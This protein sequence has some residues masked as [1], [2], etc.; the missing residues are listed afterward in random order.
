ML[1]ALAGGES[2][3]KSH[4]G[5]AVYVCAGGGRDRVKS[6]KGGLCYLLCLLVGARASSKKEDLRCLLWLTG[7]PSKL[8]DGWFILLALAAGGGPSK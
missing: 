8:H 3:S 4:E 1:L 7:S 6:V 5:W 2:P